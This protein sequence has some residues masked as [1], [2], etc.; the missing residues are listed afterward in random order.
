[1]SDAR[2]GNNERARRRGARSRGSLLTDVD[3]HL[4]HEGTHYR[5]YE[6]LGSH[7]RQAGKEA[8]VN[9]AVW[10]PNAAS[11]HV[12]G[13]FNGWDPAAHPMQPRGESGVWEAF[14]PGVERGA[15]YKY[16]IVSR[17][18][19][20]TVDKAD[21]FAFRQETPPKTASL[22]WDLDYQWGDEAWMAGRAEHNGLD[23][24]MATY[25]VHLGSWRRHE[26][27][28]LP[29]RDLAPLLA[30][31]VEEMGFTHVELLPV[32]E[33]P[34]FGSWG[35]QCT[36]Y[37]APSSRQGSPQD[38]MYLIDVLHQRG[39]GV[40]LDWVPSHFPTDEHGLAFFDGTHLFEHADPRQGYHPDWKSYIFNYTRAEVPA[41]LIS[42][43]FLW[44][45]RFHADG[46]RVDAVA[47]MLY[48]DYSRDDGGW[49][50]NRYGGKENLE[51]IDFLRKLNEA[52]YAEFP[53][54]QMIAEESTSWPAVSRPTWTGGLGFGLK[55]DMGWMHDTLEYM[56][57][58]PIHR[59]HHHNK[60]TFRML[61]AFHENFCL[62]LSHDEVVHGKGSL[63]R[64]MWGDRWQRFANL[65]LLYAYMYA[66]PAK[67]LLFMGA[68]LGQESEWNHDAEL[69]WSA[70][71]DP[72]NAGLKK[73][74]SDLNRAY[75][76]LPALHQLDCEPGGFEWID[77]NDADQS[78]LS[79]LRRDRVGEPLLILCNFTPRVREG[80]RTGVPRAGEWQE[81]LNSDAG[82]Y[83]GSGQGN[84]GTVETENISSHGHDHSLVLTLPPLGA[85]FLRPVGK[86]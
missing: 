57:Q 33:H 72:M 52:I 45:D 50:P 58:D 53:G 55:W 44:L 66:Q 24:P 3:L 84:P 69:D 18:R 79:F 65:R 16:H 64:K 8:G 4:F 21:P 12:I 78:I 73:W 61:Y 70:L 19:G 60:L 17:H 15:H 47:S 20:Y 26:G 34:F 5:L 48:L 22:V 36:G 51:A 23:R 27:A 25:E 43:A 86:G 56:V 62:P 63:I 46:I 32:M 40:L 13:S 35:Y 39:I 9:F 74:L 67:K 7:L 81:I 14:I 1:M 77:A 76:D 29:Y 42:S 80:Y 10:A 28:S 41:F 38:L 82:S 75:R 68:E 6:K 37:F 71:E 59:R 54:V 11:V 49:V 85:L 2:K 83:A 31:H 30:D